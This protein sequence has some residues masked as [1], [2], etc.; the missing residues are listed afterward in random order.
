MRKTTFTLA[1][2]WVTVAT[3]KEAV[4]YYSTPI[5]R[6]NQPKLK[7]ISILLLIYDDCE[8]IYD[9]LTQFF[10]H[11]SPLLQLILLLLL[12]LLLVASVAHVIYSYSSGLW[13]YY[14]HEIYWIFSLPILN[15][16][17]QKKKKKKKEKKKIILRQT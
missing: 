8:L 7:L 9:Y 12:L 17:G 13:E 15:F 2:A 1:T 10:Y 11:F 16:C 5:W 6:K 4:T 14:S 3:P